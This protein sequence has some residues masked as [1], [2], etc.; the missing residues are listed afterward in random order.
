MRDVV[1]P[2]PLQ[3]AAAASGFSPAVR[4]GDFVYFTGA[5]GC[6]DDGSFPASAA[7]QTRIALDKVGAILDALDAGR[8]ALVECT[9]YHTNIRDEFDSVQSALADALGTPL[10]AW[11][12]VEV[13]RL[14]RPGALVEFR[15]VAHV[16]ITE[17]RA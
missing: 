2:A 15:C 3:R 7:Q 16:P 8:D 5:V 1:C 10:P 11:T 14:R 9:S 13:Q 6:H 4:A 17:A 12:A